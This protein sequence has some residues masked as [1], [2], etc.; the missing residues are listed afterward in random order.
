MLS[1]IAALAGLVAI[2]WNSVGARAWQGRRR[3]AQA[4]RMIDV[5]LASARGSEP[6][7]RAHRQV[8]SAGMPARPDTRE[9]A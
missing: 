1:L 2:W 8:E 3:K 5:P 6:S 4:R 7:E 9:I